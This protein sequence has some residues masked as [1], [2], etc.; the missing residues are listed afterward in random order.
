MS[1]ELDKRVHFLRAENIQAL[2]HSER[3]L[4]DH[5]LGTR[6]LLVAWGS[7]PALC[8]AG[9]FHSVYGTE[10]Y[11]WAALPLSGRTELQELI[12]REA[13]S[14][15]W[16]FCVMRRDTLVA[17]LGRREGFAVGHRLDGG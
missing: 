7:R 12:G 2:E 8:D 1:E 16:L 4:L 10:G 5:L 14:L 15:A 9:L 17:N 3:G 13:E 6:Q 11:R